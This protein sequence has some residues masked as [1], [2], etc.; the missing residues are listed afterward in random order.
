M[1][2]LKEIETYTGRV[3]IKMAIYSKINQ[4]L[5]EGFTAV[6]HTTIILYNIIIMI[7]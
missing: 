1:N 2:G 3:N 4:S 7:L 5:H 6:Q